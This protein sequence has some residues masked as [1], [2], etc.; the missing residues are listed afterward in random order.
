MLNDEDFKAKRAREKEEA[1]ANSEKFIND[2]EVV[3]Q[4]K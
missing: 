1:L 4:E 3:F 2:S